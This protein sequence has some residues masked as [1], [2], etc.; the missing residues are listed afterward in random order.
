MVVKEN[1]AADGAVKNSATVGTD[2]LLLDGARNSIPDTVIQMDD[3][4][5]QKM[6][7][8]VEL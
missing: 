2:E 6:D 8:R 1:A 3:D 4:A 7:I 5:L